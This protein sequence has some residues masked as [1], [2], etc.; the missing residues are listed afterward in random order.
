MLVGRIMYLSATV[1]HLIEEDELTLAEDRQ[2]LLKVNMLQIAVNS[3]F[4]V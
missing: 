4:N 3:V 1:L 2:T